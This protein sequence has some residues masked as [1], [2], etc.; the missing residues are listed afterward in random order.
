MNDVGRRT[1]RA[2]RARRGR[3]PSEDPFELAR[4]AR[5]FA[6]SRKL[7]RPVSLAWQLARPETTQ[8]VRVTSVGLNSM[9][10]IV[11]YIVPVADSTMS[12][13][14]HPPNGEDA[15]SGGNVRFDP[16]SLATGATKVEVVVSD[17]QASRILAAVIGHGE[18][19]FQ[20]GSHDRVADESPSLEVMV[21][22]EL[23]EAE[24][25]TRDLLERIVQR[26]E[27]QLIVQVYEDCD[28]V[29]SRAAI[30]LGINRNTLLKKLRQFGAAIHDDPEE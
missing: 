20:N 1:R 23:G 16:H 13:A 24:P 28:H 25:G 8:T 14:S 4:V 21:L 3:T 9:K 30:R 7:S 12:D 15:P 5:R 2:S 11:T 26:I 27:R 22:K 29:K 10:R 18:S 17:E 19:E 6:G